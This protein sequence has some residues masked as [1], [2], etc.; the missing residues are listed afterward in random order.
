MRRHA[1]HPRAMR[2]FK[3]DTGSEIE[4]DFILEEVWKHV[5]SRLVFVCGGSAGFV[6]NRQS[7]C[8]LPSGKIMHEMSTCL[9]ACR[10]FANL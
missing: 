4:Q 5:A 3:L 7:L 8:N 2:S 9:S 6:E 1:L 10:D